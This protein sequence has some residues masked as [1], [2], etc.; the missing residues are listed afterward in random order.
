MRYLRRSDPEDCRMKNVRLR[1]GDLPAALPRLPGPACGYRT[2]P[3]RPPGSRAPQPVS[4]CL[5]SLS[6]AVHARNRVPGQAV[7]RDILC[8]PYFLRRIHRFVKRP[9]YKAP[10]HFHFLENLFLNSCLDLF[11]VCNELE[12]GSNLLIQRMTCIATRAGILHSVTGNAGGHR[13]VIF[14][15]KLRPFCDRTMAL[16]TGSAMQQMGSV[17]ECH[18]R[19]QLINPNPGNWRVGFGIGRELLNVRIGC[20]DGLVTLH[21]ERCRRNQDCIAR[22]RSCVAVLEGHVQRARVLFVAERDRLQRRQRLPGSLSGCADRCGSTLR[23][24]YLRGLR[25][26]WQ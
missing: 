9:S 13:Y 6:A 1:N 2:P 17:T 22:S 16:L 15:I 23:K 19:R 25:G 24:G 8:G 14:L 26:G 10:P 4:G 7:N 21:A 18:K 5:H 12:D 3:L 20:V 11:L